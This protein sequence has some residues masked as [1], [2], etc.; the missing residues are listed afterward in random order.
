MLSRLTYIINF[1]IYPIWC[2][3][4]KYFEK[5][6]LD[7]FFILNLR[8]SKIFLLTRFKFSLIMKFKSQ[9]SSLKSKVNPA[10]CC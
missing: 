1:I 3:L 5:N 10:L 6:S 4:D 8:L 2:I 9:V 7:I